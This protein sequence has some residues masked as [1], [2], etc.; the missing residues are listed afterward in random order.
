MNGL[1]CNHFGPK[2]EHGHLFYRPALQTV[3]EK[4]HTVLFSNKVRVW[5]TGSHIKPKI[6]RNRK[7]SVLGTVLHALK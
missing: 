6:Q 3:I 4:F 2:S 1:D 5:G 7:H